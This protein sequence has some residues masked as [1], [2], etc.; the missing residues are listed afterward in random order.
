MN[1]HPP[2]TGYAS[3][4]DLRIETNERILQLLADII[5]KLDTS[6]VITI[7]NTV[8][9]DERDYCLRQLRYQRTKFETLFTNFVTN[10][11]FIRERRKVL[12][13][14]SKEFPTSTVRHYIEYCKLWNQIGLILALARQKKDE[15]LPTATAT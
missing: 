13:T 14:L 5:E 12:H 15:S 4:S 1:R 8:N 6:I 7:E 9:R 3:Y 11:A 10:T 2:L